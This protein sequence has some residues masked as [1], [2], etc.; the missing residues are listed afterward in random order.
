MTSFVARLSQNEHQGY[1]RKPE[2]MVM[3]QPEVCWP[4]G[5]AGNKGPQLY[6]WHSVVGRWSSE[7]IPRPSSA[8]V[9]VGCGELLD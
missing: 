9:W 8:D 2:Y 5:R 4:I 3:P 1:M 6:V 7:Y